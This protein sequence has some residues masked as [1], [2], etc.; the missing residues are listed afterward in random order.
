GHALPIMFLSGAGGLFLGITM[1]LRL[2]HIPLLLLGI[3][4]GALTFYGLLFALAFII[5]P[6][7][8]TTI[9]SMHHA[10]DGVVSLMALIASNLGL[11]AWW[12][13]HMRPLFIWLATPLFTY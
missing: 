9:P 4:G 5:G 13:L 12:Q 6:P 8:T 2:R 1:K 10:Y 3:T 7:L 11:G